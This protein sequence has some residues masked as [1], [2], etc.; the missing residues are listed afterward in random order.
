MLT[1]HFG[2][3][4]LSF[5]DDV[6]NSVNNM[7]Y[8]AS[9]A[10]QEF[11]EGQMEELVVT[12]RLKVRDFDIKVDTGKSMH[13]FET[14][15]EASVDK[16]FDRF[17]LYALKN[18]FG[19]PEDVD[20]VLPHYEALDFGI[21]VEREEQ[22][23]E[24]LE[25]LRRQLIA[26]KALNFKLRKQLE[27]EENRRRQLEKCREQI[28]FL[29][30]VANEYP[31]VTPVPQTLIFVRDNIETLHRRFESL[32]ERLS[33]N[34]TRANSYSSNG[35]SSTVA[36]AGS[37]PPSTASIASTPSTPSPYPPPE[38]VTQVLADTLASMEPDKRMIYIRSVVRRQVQ[39][40]LASDPFM[41]AAV[42]SSGGSSGAGTNIQFHELLTP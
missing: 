22:L 3:S 9:M 39:E 23:N 37:A 10:L 21:S 42:G 32:H 12:D 1:E 41:S 8:Q 26:T 14:L 7:I 34:T 38:T 4:P 30:D 5:V 31:D 28:R 40:H 2:F 24:Q 16:N 20:I 33:Q 36:A 17:E 25:L 29:K 11:V 19:V 15:L 27:I 6:I 35:S 18:I 13:K